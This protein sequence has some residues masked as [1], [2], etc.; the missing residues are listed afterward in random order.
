MDRDV[1]CFELIDTGTHVINTTHAQVTVANR[2]SN[3]AN[4]LSQ[5]LNE[6]AH[7]LV[8]L[9]NRTFCAEVSMLKNG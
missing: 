7:V 3:E 5:A 9:L 8:L 6:N 1:K 4:V 2:S